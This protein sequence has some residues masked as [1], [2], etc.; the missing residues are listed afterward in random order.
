MITKIVIPLLLAILLTWLYIDRHCLKHLLK[1][2]WHHILWW[3]P[4]IIMAVATLL[5]GTSRNFAPDN[6][7]IIN[8]YLFMV[9][10]MVIPATLYV[11]CSLTGWMLQRLCHTTRNYGNIAGVMAVLVSWFILIYGTTKGFSQI[12]V[13]QQTYC[14]DQLPDAFDGYRIVHFSDA[15]VGTYSGRHAHLLAQAVDSINAQRA[16]LIVFTGDLQNRMPSEIHPH[17][18]TLSRLH[19]KD[20]VVSVMG[21]HDYPHYITADS[22]QRRDSLHETQQLQRSMGWTLLMNEHITVHRHADSII[23]AGMENDGTGKPFPSY[24]NIRKTLQGT[25][26]RQFAVMLQHDPSS[27]RRTILPQSA[28]QLTLS[29]HTHATQFALLGWSPASL[30]YKEW[31]GMYHEGTRAIHVSTGLG[32]F[33]PFRFGVPGE[34]T[35]ITLKKK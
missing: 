22:S 25:R 1:K 2:R 20:G 8:I 4:A 35:V 21:N 26:P 27:W 33:I 19:A 15:H 16:D 23:V 5:L 32:G 34:I 10:L 24:G 29:G 6:I 18:S 7:T 30:I 14:S 12:T 3:S 31:G 9:G 28:A 17:L 13:K 11:L